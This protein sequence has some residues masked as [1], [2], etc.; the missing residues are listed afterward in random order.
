MQ[1]SKKILFGL[2][3]TLT[4]ADCSLASA[5]PNKIKLPPETAKLRKS[6]LPGYTLATQKCVVCH[7]ADYI[8]FQAPNLNQAQWTGEVQKMQHS[9]GARFSDA[10]VK[11][12]GAYLAVAYG[13][14]KETDA[15]VIAA[16]MPSMPSTK[17]NDTIDAQELLKGNAC[18]SCHAVDKKLVG[19]SFHDI[20]AK[21]QGDA[22][23]HSKLA[24]SIQKGSVGNWGQVPMPPMS[25]VTPEQAKEIA[26][27]IMQQ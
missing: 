19:P 15:S 13:S 2:V 22:L 21:Y 24:T 4:I 27:F 9:Y 25:N 16:S 3:F 26:I 7:S 6:N 14:A 8:N 10:E 20:A 11:S 18:L 12:I 5:A 17:A 1:A 23:A